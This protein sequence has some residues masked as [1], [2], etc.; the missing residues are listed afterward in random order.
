MEA[1]T[2]T[3]RRGIEGAYAYTLRSA[4]GANDEGTADTI[5]AMS[6]LALE[7]AQHDPVTIEVAAGILEDTGADPIGL[8]RAVYDFLRESVRF[9]PDPPGRELLRTPEQLLLEIARAGRTRADCDEN[10]TLG[11][12]LLLALGIPAALITTGRS[13]SGPF[14]HVFFGAQLGGREW[15]PIDP[16]ER[17]YGVWNPRALRRMVWEVHPDEV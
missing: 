6:A 5:G 9:R 17:R 13:A 2:L 8:A 11:A 16:Q 14:S 1:L 12:A 7:A 3:H 10:A 4:V 15:F